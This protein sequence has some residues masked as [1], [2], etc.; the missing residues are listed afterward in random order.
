[1]S[2]EVLI[3][4]RKVTPRLTYVA[5]YIFEQRLGINFKLTEKL[6]VA[7]HDYIINYSAEKVEGALQIIPSS[8]LY[9]QGIKTGKPDVFQWQAS[10]ALFKTDENAHITFDVFAAIFWM[11]T[12]YEEYQDFAPDVY[13]RFPARESLA[14]ANGF[15]MQPV[16][17]QWL[18]FF[19]DKMK[20]AFPDLTLK[21]EHYQFQPTL[22]ID[23]AWCYKNKGLARNVG[24]ALRDLLN[25]DFS[26]VGQRVGVLLG[27]LPD[28][29]FQFKYIG[30]IHDKYK[31]Q[32][33][34]FMHL[35]NRGKYDKNINFNNKT[36]KALIKQL[37]EKYTLGIH[38]SYVA[39]NNSAQMEVE[40]L[41]LEKISGY[42]VEHSRQHFLKF[43]LPDYYQQLIRLNI[44]SDYSMGY[45]D[46]PGFR[47]GTSK[48]FYFYDLQIESATKL[49]VCPFVVMDVTLQQYLNLDA[50]KAFILIKELI[51]KLKQ[52]NGTFV[53]LWHNE[54]LSDQFQWKG[55]RQLYE[56]MILEAQC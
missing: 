13:G 40:K 9:E 41:R 6:P 53:S 46:V 18:V 21:Q 27:M 48:T 34:I 8:L 39:A 55:W 3:Y 1:M 33:K 4:S 28:P 51:D 20:S 45:A 24:G 35:G 50:Q 26:L 30:N 16:V 19:K 15:L 49:L 22:D 36:F 2:S 5:Q 14:H 54:S 7:S 25:G 17:D 32:P 23:S 10:V 38:P 42:P 11:L 43:Q 52:V 47:A 37:S 56:K 12:R 29:F 31:V 44:K